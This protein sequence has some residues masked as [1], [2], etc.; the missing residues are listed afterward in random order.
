MRNR[1]TLGQP[2]DI[3]FLL[4]IFFLLLSGIASSGSVP[5][6][7]ESS[8]TTETPG[9][10]LITLTILEDGSIL[11]G[12]ETQALQSIAKLIASA[13]HVSILV[14]RNTSWQHVVALLSIIEQQSTASFSLE[15]SDE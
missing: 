13:K 15:L 1:R 10:A 12:D 6:S 9:T 7:L 11:L 14:R 2:S 8:E 5:I 3:A 4:I